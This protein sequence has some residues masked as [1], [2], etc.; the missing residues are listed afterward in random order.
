[1]SNIVWVEII[2]YI[3]KKILE[4]KSK[5]DAVQKA[6]SKFGVSESD[7]WKRGGF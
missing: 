5:K 7:I 1:M 2:A 6:A 3:I 4:G